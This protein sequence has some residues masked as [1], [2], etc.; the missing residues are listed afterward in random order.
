MATHSVE[1]SKTV[2]IALLGN[3]HQQMQ[4]SQISLKKKAFLIKKIITKKA[5][6][7]QEENIGFTTSQ[8]TT[9]I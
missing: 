5:R 9:N 7:L 4:Q 1:Q 6:C 8:L 2:C 3:L